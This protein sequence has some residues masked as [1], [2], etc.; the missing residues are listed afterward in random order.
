[1]SEHVLP[2][3]SYTSSG[4]DTQ[5]GNHPD[6]QTPGGSHLSGTMGRFLRNNLRD[7]GMFISLI[8]IGLFFEIMT[9]G[10]LLRP[11]NLTNLILQNSYIVVMALGMLLVIISGHIDLSVAR[12]PGLLER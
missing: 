11:L 5:S 9:N 3:G 6:G 10:T 4:K 7:Y 1:M 2:P 8:A 12:S